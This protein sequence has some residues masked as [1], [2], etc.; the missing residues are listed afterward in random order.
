MQEDPPGSGIWAQKCV[1]GT[2]KPCTL[3]PVP[4]LCEDPNAFDPGAGVQ[5]LCYQINVTEA[6]CPK[7]CGVSQHDGVPYCSCSASDDASCRQQLP[8]EIHSVIALEGGGARRLLAS[9]A[10]WGSRWEGRQGADEGTFSGWMWQ[11]RRR[12]DG[13][14]V[15]R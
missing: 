1:V 9:C 15:W 5:Y 11:E 4:Q 3:P 2:S 8:G 6:E 10:G 13:A 14:R 12:A 7:G